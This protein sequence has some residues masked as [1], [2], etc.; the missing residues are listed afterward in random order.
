MSKGNVL[1]LPGAQ[2]VRPVHPPAR[3]TACGLLA[4]PSAIDQ[5]GHIQLFGIVFQ[6]CTSR[7]E[8]TPASTVIC[9]R[10]LEQMMRGIRKGLGIRPDLNPNDSDHVKAAQDHITSQQ[11]N[12]SG[13][14]PDKPTV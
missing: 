7:G 6:F 5:P 14:Q 9:M 10:C 12:P 8:I 2:P 1:K 4:K 11:E 3:C 13:N